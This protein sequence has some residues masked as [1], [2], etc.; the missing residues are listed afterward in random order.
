M[1][2][3]DAKGSA[4]VIAEHRLVPLVRVGL[5]DIYPRSGRLEELIDRYN[6]GV[7]GIVAAAQEAILKKAE[8]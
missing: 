8:R 3:A 5:R 4:E 2:T 1:V 6:M 7:S